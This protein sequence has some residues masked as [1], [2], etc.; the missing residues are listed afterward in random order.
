MAA[1]VTIAPVWNYLLPDS[2]FFQW[3][4]VFCR[5]QCTRTRNRWSWKASPQ[6]KEESLI[7]E[8]LLFEAFWL[9]K[10]NGLV[11]MKYLKY[12]PSDMSVTT[13]PFA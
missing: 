5:S 8:K 7:C 2:P 10:A 12:L 3:D 11:P 13:S 4:G 9:S 6:K 1:R